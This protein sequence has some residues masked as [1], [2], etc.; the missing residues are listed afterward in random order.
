VSDSDKQEIAS[1]VVDSLYDAAKDIRDLAA[2][3]L[4]EI[5]PIAIEIVLSKQL[6]KIPG[7]QHGYDIAKHIF[8]AMGTSAIEELVRQIDKDVYI[9]TNALCEMPLAQVRRACSTIFLRDSFLGRYREEVVRKMRS[10][11]DW[12]AT[13][14]RELLLSGLKHLDP[15]VRVLSAE[16]LI[17]SFPGDSASLAELE[18]DMVLVEKFYGPTRPKKVCEW[19]RAALKGEPESDTTVA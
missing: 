12:D 19:V 15:L 6:W 18:H 17:K 5:G 10:G 13:E 9:V 3:I 8:V 1:I 11:Q 4:T 14:L 7:R 2:A 16:W